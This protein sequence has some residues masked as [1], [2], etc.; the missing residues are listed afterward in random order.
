MLNILFQEGN[1]NSV[2]VADVCSQELNKADNFFGAWFDE[3]DLF[4]LFSMLKFD[5]SSVFLKNQNGDLYPDLFFIFEGEDAPEAV[6][7]KPVKYL[8]SVYTLLQ[9]FVVLKENTLSHSSLV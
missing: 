8:V 2:E 7:D 4:I 6:P 5:F 1:I 3:Y 9:F